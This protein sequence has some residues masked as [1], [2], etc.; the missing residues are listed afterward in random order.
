[1]LHWLLT[2][3]A[4][5]KERLR[6]A[7][8]PLSLLGETGFRAPSREAATRSRAYEVSMPSFWGLLSEARIVQRSSGANRAPQLAKPYRPVLRPATCVASCLVGLGYR[9]TT[10]ARTVYCT[11]SLMPSQPGRGARAARAAH[12][13]RQGVV[14]SRSGLPQLGGGW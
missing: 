13:R 14:I 1:M 4:V 7:R 5:F 8:V 6:S 10:A 3:C 11:L 12:E 9:T 2:H